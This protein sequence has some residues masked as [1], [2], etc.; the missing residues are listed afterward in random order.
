MFAYATAQGITLRLDGSEIQVRR[1]R[2]ASP[3]GGASVSGKKKMF[4]VLPRPDSTMASSEP[5]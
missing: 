1:P 5:G 2:R 4:L 3:A